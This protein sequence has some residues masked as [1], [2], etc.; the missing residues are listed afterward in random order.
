MQMYI[1]NFIYF[2]NLSFDNNN[3]I[4]ICTK[5]NIIIYI[6]ICDNNTK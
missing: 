4:I 3:K 2:V 1:I 5:P 6:N